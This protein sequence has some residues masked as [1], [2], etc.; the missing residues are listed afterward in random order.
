MTLAAW[1]SAA[2]KFKPTESEV[3]VREQVVRQPA[4]PHRLRYC[5]LTGRSWSKWFRRGDEDSECDGDRGLTIL[6]YNPRPACQ[7][8]NPLPVNS[9]AECPFRVRIS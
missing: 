6:L 1:E 3:G 4:P 9:V 7:R 8:S 5:D 2:P